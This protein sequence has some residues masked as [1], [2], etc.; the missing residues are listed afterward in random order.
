[1]TIEEMRDAYAKLQDE[2]KTALSEL[3]Q[4]KADN[5][6]SKAR[7]KELEDYNRK[8]FSKYVL[9]DEKSQDE[10]KPL[11]DNVIDKIKENLK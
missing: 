3:E 5:E 8:L 6:T 11:M 4:L 9:S 2:H 7:I 10:E 1:M